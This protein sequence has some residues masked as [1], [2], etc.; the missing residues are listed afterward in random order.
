MHNELLQTYLAPI[1]NSDFPYSWFSFWLHYLIQNYF[2]ITVNQSVN[3]CYIWSHKSW[4]PRHR[5]HHWW[6]PTLRLNSQFIDH[7]NFKL[8]EQFHQNS[9]I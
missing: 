5:M 2:V 7:V 9:V 8:L 3:L 4:S 1:H 6:L